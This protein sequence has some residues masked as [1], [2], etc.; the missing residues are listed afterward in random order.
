ML[1]D[2]FR[3]KPRYV[4]VK[5]QTATKTSE[6]ERKNQEQSLWIKCEGCGELLYQ[7]EV[8]KNLYV[9]PKCNYHFRINARM[10]LEQLVD[11]DTFIEI[12]SNLVSSDPLNFPSYKDKLAKSLERTKLKEAV[13]TGRAQIGGHPVMF[14]VIDFEFMGGSMGSAVGE[15]ITRMFEQSL[16]T[17][18]PVVMVSAGGGG[19]RM[20]EGILS[21][22]Q[23]AKTSQA[24][25]RIL[26]AGIPYFSVLTDPT[27]GGVYAS[28]ASLA[29]VIVA[30][31][32]A[33]IGFAGPRVVEETIRQK[34]P[35]GF[36]TA[37][38]AMENGMIDLIVERKDL[39]EMLI[40]L[41]GM[42]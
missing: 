28:F 19:A 15:K 24:V 4:T 41:L 39:K 5:S 10:R 7:K 9:C 25:G 36:Q 29:D 18:F 27:M 33:L 34:L 31:P 37:E 3:S 11:P 12:N 26:D 22:M 13:L 32:K 14:G 30:E 17:R 2:L 38:F 42:H 40:K 35:Q 6:A 23:M 8:A 21:L 20:Q 1:K 16:E